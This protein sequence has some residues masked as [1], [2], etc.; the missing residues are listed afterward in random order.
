[1]TYVQ[2]IATLITV[3]LF[4]FI[5]GGSIVSW[6]LWMTGQR[7]KQVA[8]GP[9]ATVGMIDL[10]ATLAILIVLM[11][12]AI[13]VWQVIKA[14]PADSQRAAVPLSTQSSLDPASESAP[15]TAIAKPSDGKLTEK[16]F[17]FSAFAISSQLLCVVLSTVF[18]CRRTSC[19]LRRLG[20]KTDQLRGDLLAGLQCFLM[21]TP[22][23]IILNGLLSQA[24]KVPYEHPIQKMIEEYPWLLGIAFWQASVVAPISEEYAFRALLIGW[25]ESIHFG[26]KKL[27]AFVFGLPVDPKESPV[28]ADPFQKL[29]S[30]SELTHS[31]RNPYASSSSIANGLEPARDEFGIDIPTAAFVAAAKDP[32]GTTPYNPPWWPALLSGVLFGLA[33]F[34][35]GVSWVNLILFGIVLGR[36]YQIRQS[37]LP[38]ILVHFLFN[39]MSIAMFA[40]KLLLPTN[41]VEP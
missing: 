3:G 12:I 1:M 7:P 40:L 8:V 19:S 27:E 11:S 15:T 38:V 10:V 9:Q 25:F 28:I 17:T 23:I 31:D 2:S 14:Q 13:S 18:V 6:T 24:T 33:H 32:I 35:Y 4:F 16:Q 39:S 5:L 41:L 34:N 36:L 21:I 22:P 26:Y 30:N 29:A 20:W 37:L